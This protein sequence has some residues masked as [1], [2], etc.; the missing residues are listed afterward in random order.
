MSF[1]AHEM[2]MP[3]G[4]IKTQAQIASIAARRS[5]PGKTAL[6]NI[7]RKSDGPNGFGAAKSLSGRSRAEMLRDT[8]TTG[9]QE[10]RAAGIGRLGQLPR[11]GRFFDEQPTVS[12]FQ[13]LHDGE[14]IFRVS[15]PKYLTVLVHPV[16]SP[17]KAGLRQQV[18]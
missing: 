1:A 8:R 11:L 18:A 14:C 6:A 7:R 15:I 10:A 13:W 9:L 3:F 12:R 2:K 4:R 16:V 5:G 17:N